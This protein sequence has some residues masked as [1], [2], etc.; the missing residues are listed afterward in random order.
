[1]QTVYAS[2]QSYKA[3]VYVY[4]KDRTDG[5]QEIDSGDWIQWQYK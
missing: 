4:S 2:D 5:L 3:L 1:M